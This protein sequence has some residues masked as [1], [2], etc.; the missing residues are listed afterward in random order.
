MTG[1]GRRKIRAVDYHNSAHMFITAFEKGLFG[2][3]F[4]DQDQLDN[5]YLAVQGTMLRYKVS[6]FSDFG[7][8]LDF[9]EKKTGDGD[10]DF[11]VKSDDYCEHLE[12]ENSEYVLTLPEK[13]E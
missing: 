10:V 9:N 5:E 12:G 6:D 13:D 2:K 7:E 1:M 11:T 3:L 4:W 8:K